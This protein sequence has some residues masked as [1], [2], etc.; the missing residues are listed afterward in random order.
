MLT[1]RKVQTII[2]I[3]LVLMTSC[4]FK[5]KM[6]DEED[7]ADR[8][9]VQ[10]YDRLESRYLTTSDFSALQSMNINYPMQTRTLVEDVLRLGEVNDPHINTKFLSFFQDSA[11]QTIISDA[12][13]QYASMDDINDALTSSFEK[14]KKLLPEVELP[15]VYAQ[16][17]ALDQSIIVGDQLIGISLDKYLG[18]DY[19]LY[20]HY[21]PEAQRESMS[22][23]YIVPDCIN[24]YLL[25]LYQMSDYDQRTQR[26]KDLHMGK[27][28]WT[29]N[30][31]TPQPVYHSRYVTAVDRYM[32]HHHSVTVKQLLESDDY[33]VFTEVR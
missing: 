10:R 19:P 13:A 2:L 11:L 9:E 7:A 21:Y 3:I 30:K 6:S 27:I 33:S 16:I 15:Q 18:S 26:E 17:G 14:L 8:I 12:E 1:V 5:L 23:K 4:E 32:H 25:S 28:M 31:V 22:R 29:V 20:K 24:F